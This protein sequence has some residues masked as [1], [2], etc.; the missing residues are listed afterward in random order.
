LRQKRR[1][2]LAAHRHSGHN[3]I[4]FAKVAFRQSDASR[5]DVPLQP[6]HP[7]GARNRHELGTGFVPFS[8]LGKGFLTGPSP[9]HVALPEDRQEGIRGS[10]RA[11]A[12]QVLARLPP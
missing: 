1:T 8:A 7:G 2:T 5:A 6:V 9:P 10:H 4:D 12:H 11:C 3:L